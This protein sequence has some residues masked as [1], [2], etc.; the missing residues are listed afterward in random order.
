MYARRT[1]VRKLARSGSTATTCSVTFVPLLTLG[2]RWRRSARTSWQINA[3]HNENCL[4]WVRDVTLRRD[5]H[6]ARTATARRRRGS[7]QQRLRLHHS[8]GETDIARAT[9]RANRRP[10]ISLTP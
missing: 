10:T 6:Q 9:R 5:A 1:Q 3:R 4:R 2:Y 8:N 7:P